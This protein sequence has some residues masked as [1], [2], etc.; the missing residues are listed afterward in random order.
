[1]TG[2]L[3]YIGSHTV[4]ELLKKDFKIIILDNLETSSMKC[5]EKLRIISNKPKS[6]IFYQYDLSNENAISEIFKTF[7]IKSVIHCASLNSE[8]ESLSKPLKFYQTNICGTV[9]LLRLMKKYE[10]K[11]FIYSSDA[12]IYGR[13]SICKE[14]DGLD[15]SNPCGHT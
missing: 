3:G 9:T 14:S 6:V 10:V 12:N 1:M 4:V 7:S 13:N 8:N 15:P 11:T 5:L 2:G